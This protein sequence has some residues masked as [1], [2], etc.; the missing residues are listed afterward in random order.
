ML[1]ELTPTQKVIAVNKYLINIDEVIRNETKVLNLDD[2]EVFTKIKTVSDNMDETK[3][4]CTSF[5]L[6]P[7]A[8]MIKHKNNININEPFENNKNIIYDKLTESYYYNLYLDITKYKMLD[9]IKNINCNYELTKLYFLHN[10]EIKC[11]INKVT[12]PIVNM[13]YIPINFLIKIDKQEIINIDLSFDAYTI[14]N[15]YRKCFKTST[16]YITNDENIV[17]REGQFVGYHI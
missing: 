17:F 3:I 4:I 10:L 7:T 13:Y 5:I 12:L 15:G 2:P 1:N 9:I 8:V 6:Y 14:E 11:D 16:K